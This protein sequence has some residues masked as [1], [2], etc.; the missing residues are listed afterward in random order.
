MTD[1]SIPADEAG[2]TGGADAAE[3][4]EGA[5]RGLPAVLA[6]LRGRSRSGIRAGWSR[7]R[8]GS[9]LALQAG[10][11]AALAWYVAHDLIGRQSPFFAPIAAVITLASSVGQRARRTAELVLGVAIGIGIGDAI[12]LLIGSGPWQIGLI[13]VFAILVAAAVGGGTPLV[14]QS[15]SSAV[16]VA[17]LTSVTGLPYTR[18][19][20]ALVGGAVG[21]VVMTVLLPLN[22]LTVV[23]RAADPALDAMA[24]GLRAVAAGMAENDAEGVREAL[25]QLRATEGNFAAFA[26]AAA[27][28]SENVAFAPA[29]WRSRGALGQYVEGAPHLTY[30]L[31][32]VRVLARRAITAMGDEEHIPSCL[33]A[34]V[35]L[36]GDA[37]ELLR[38][39]WARGAEPEAT[40]ER[41]LRAA[42]E[43]GQAYDEGVGFSGGVV[44]AQVRTTVT[45]LLRATGIEYAEAPRL[46][47]RAVGWHGRGRTARRRS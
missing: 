28:A 29:R 1:R 20:D 5:Q 23:R 19:F 13:V 18:F 43:S 25:A 3:P 30:A 9:G 26:A 24:E 22:P 38:Q 27:A 40:R 46:V 16:L 15:A 41:A 35:G 31:R 34:S 11:G 7:V 32:N 42:A 6:E 47:R 17:T 14:V 2:R 33:P 12:I 21:L 39:E 36:L 45:D 4:D 8:A 10:V 37:V 44:V